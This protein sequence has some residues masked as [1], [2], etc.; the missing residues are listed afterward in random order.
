MAVLHSVDFSDEISKRA[1]LT[2]SKQLPGKHSC[3]SMISTYLKSHFPL[4]E[5]FLEISRL[6]TEV[7]SHILFLFFS[8][9]L[10]GDE[11]SKSILLIS[12]EL[13]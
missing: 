12:E 10:P 13:L 4:I 1:V 3:E 7:V 5:D 8:Y 11:V 9:S 2:I 6:F